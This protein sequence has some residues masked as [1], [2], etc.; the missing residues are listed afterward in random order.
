MEAIT[1][2]MSISIRPP[3]LSTAPTASF[4]GTPVIGAAP[5]TVNFA[6][7]DTHV[8]AYGWDFGDGSTSSAPNPS[9][10]YTTP[11][12]QYTVIHTATNLGGDVTQTRTNYITTNATVAAAFNGTPVSGNIPLS[13]TFTDA[14]TGSPYAWNWSFGDGTVGSTQNPTHS[15]TTAGSFTVRLDITTPDGTAN[16]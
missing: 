4:T 16:T 6:N 14:S 11:S 13:V 5:L 1:T 9:H 15:Y 10:Q 2:E 3:L 7:S 8:T 12:T